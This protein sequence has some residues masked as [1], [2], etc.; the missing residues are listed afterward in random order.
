[1]IRNR[2]NSVLIQ[3]DDFSKGRGDSK[4]LGLG[5]IIGADIFSEPG[6]IK[7]GGALTED[8]GIEFTTQ[9]LAAAQ[10]ASQTTHTSYWAVLSGST[11]K[12]YKRTDSTVVGTWTLLRNAVQYIIGKMVVFNG[13]LYYTGTS[14][15]RYKIGGSVTMDIASPCTVTFTGHGMAA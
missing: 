13:Y 4:W 6:V 5:D 12:I 7:N 10:D 2:D 9:I 3:A 11:S 14:L 15:G 1:M 8:T